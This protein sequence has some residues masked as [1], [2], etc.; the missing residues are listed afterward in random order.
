MRA[1]TGHL[2]ITCPGGAWPRTWEPRSAAGVQTPP[3][4]AQALITH[5]ALFAS[6]DG[7]QYEACRCRHV[8]VTSVTLLSVFSNIWPPR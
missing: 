3:V 6:G 8:I 5:Q 4:T 7:F 1:L 2:A